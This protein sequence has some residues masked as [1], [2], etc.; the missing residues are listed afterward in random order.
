[1]HQA[2][3]FFAT[4]GKTLEATNLLVKSLTANQYL[5]AADRQKLETLNESMR[6]AS[7]QSGKFVEQRVDNNEKALME[8]ARAALK[9]GDFEI[10]EVYAK[11]ALTVQAKMHFNPLAD[12]P[13]KVLARHRQARKAA[14]AHC[15]WQSAGKEGIVGRIQDRQQFFW[16]GVEG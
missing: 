8:A 11:Q 3:E 2:E 15:Q 6:M 7:A 9:R 13:S 4:Q 16:Q 5:A 1:M 12:T 14:N 10:A